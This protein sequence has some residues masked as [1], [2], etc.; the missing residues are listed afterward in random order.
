LAKHFAQ[1]LSEKY[2]F[3]LFTHARRFVRRRKSAVAADFLLPRCD[4][5]WAI[6]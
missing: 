5:T 3:R 1:E 4:T 2:P 6:L